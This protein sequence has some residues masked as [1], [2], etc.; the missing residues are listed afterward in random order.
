M[1]TKKIN[2][3]YYHMP[4]SVTNRVQLDVTQ[5]KSCRPLDAQCHV[6][7]VI[8]DSVQSPQSL[9]DDNTS[10]TDAQDGPQ[11]LIVELF[12]TWPERVLVLAELL[13][14][15]ELL[16]LRSRVATLLMLSLLSITSKVPQ[17]SIV[18]DRSEELYRREHVG[19]V[20]HDNEG[21]VDE[22]VSEVADTC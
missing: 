13:Q 21:N 18:C 5:R 9:L 17:K 19:A 6:P 3:H 14:L 11:P 4:M 8:C 10:S 22:G 15:G 16:G 20:E 7:A 1:T 2:T 12:S